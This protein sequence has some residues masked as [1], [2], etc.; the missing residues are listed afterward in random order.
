MFSIRD[1]VIVDGATKLV[2][3]YTSNVFPVGVAFGYDKSNDS[4]LIVA[5]H[6][7]KG[8]TVVTGDSVLSAAG[9]DT[10]PNAADLSWAL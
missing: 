9:V 4:L 10:V 6:H 5:D 1:F 3:S 2:N 8:W 7:D